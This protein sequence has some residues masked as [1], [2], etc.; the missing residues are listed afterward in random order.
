VKRAL[1]KL[2][3]KLSRLGLAG[4]AVDLERELAAETSVPVPG[5]L[6][7]SL[8]SLATGAG[9]A[10]PGALLSA[11]GGAALLALVGA[12]ALVL[13]RGLSDERGE[14]RAA[15]LTPP[16]LAAAGATRDAGG[17]HTPLPADERVAIA[18]GVGEAGASREAD[19]PPAALPSGWIE[20][21]VAD[22]DGVAV[23]GV[24][25][26]A[27]S[28][29]QEGKGERVL[30]TAVSD[31][32]GRWRVEVPAR[33]DGHPYRVSAAHD[34][35]VA[36]H[37]K[38][39]V[40]VEPG[41]TVRFPAMT[42]LRRSD[43]VPA[44]Y[45]LRVTVVDEGGAPVAGVSVA[46]YRRWDPPTPDS[47]WMQ[48]RESGASTDPSGIALLTGRYLGEKVVKV[49]GA[50]AGFEEKLVDAAIPWAGAHNLEVVLGRGRS[51][52]GSLLDPSGAPVQ[53][54]VVKALRVG[55]PGDDWFHSDVAADGGF[56][57]NGLEDG[58][59]YDIFTQ[60]DY[61]LAGQRPLEP[62]PFTEPFE[63]G[64]PIPYEWGWSTAYLSGVPAGTEGLAI[65]LKRANDTLTGGSFR[66]EV[67]GRLVDAATGAVV[68]GDWEAVE[69][70]WIAA[71]LTEEQL[72]ADVYPSS[73][74]PR[75]VQKMFVSAPPPPSSRFHL[76]GLRPGSFLVAARVPGYAT[77]F[78]GPFHLEIGD[79]VA[80]VELRLER[81]ASLSGSVLDV[82]GSVLAGVHLMVTGTGPGSEGRIA[83]FDHKLRD[84]NGSSRWYY[85]G[86]G[87][88]REDG[89]FTFPNLAP[90][91]SYRVVA[92]H[93]E[94]EPVWAEVSGLAAGEKREGFTLSFTA[95]RSR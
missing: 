39:T 68:E 42:V 88:A 43:E 46:V 49:A 94:R 76:V 33:E 79:V 5:G 26:H 28:M 15:A 84:T 21:R 65:G 64:P 44:E 25:V 1:E 47:S 61:L 7:R 89:T 17:E 56:A 93:P 86:N 51:I 48:Y 18:A 22:L 92:L 66:P 62:M 19:D 35:F 81:P 40:Q 23:T 24:T 57:L 12:A 9:A 41:A 55:G 69:M 72:R 85:E 71:G 38:E 83:G 50:R 91:L 74:W 45:D 78:A 75:P 87:R 58:A 6:E 82:D 27:L 36:Y 95:A 60:Q 10:V 31:L 3:G 77:A 11:V 90:G 13:G 37:S 63:E 73:L 2:R 8:L 54:V 16:A 34:D 59:A 67:H 53:G 14:G 30:G 80:D 4:F 70:E 52:T 29:A 32:D 20:G